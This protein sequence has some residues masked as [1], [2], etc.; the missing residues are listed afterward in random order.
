MLHTV[1][2]FL[3]LFQLAWLYYLIMCIVVFS[4]LLFTLPA[5]RVSMT[6]SVFRLPKTLSQQ[7]GAT[8][9]SEY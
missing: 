9:C 5:P 1:F 4:C 8:E 2:A 3:R 6:P 7:S